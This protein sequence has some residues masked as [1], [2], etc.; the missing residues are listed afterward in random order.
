MLRHASVI[1]RLMTVTV[2][3][4]RWQ[5]CRGLSER[6]EP[7]HTR[8]TP[9]IPVRVNGRRHGGKILR[10]GR[11]LYAKFLSIGTRVGVWN[12]KYCKIYEISERW[13]VYLRWFS[14]ILRIFVNASFTDDRHL[15]WGSDLAHSRER[16]SSL[17]VCF[18]SDTVL[19]SL[20][21]GRCVD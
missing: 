2:S 4:H 13:S 15:P 5:P 16:K 21:R 6:T 8:P 17:F 1:Y 12:P 7:L 14:Q 11:P 19:I 3:H 18:R 9:A 20:D 10:A